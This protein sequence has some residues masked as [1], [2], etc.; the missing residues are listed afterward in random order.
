VASDADDLRE[1]TAEALRRTG[2][3]DVAELGRTP[4]FTRLEAELSMCLRLRLGL[5]CTP[6]RPR[7][8]AEVAR[9]MSIGGRIAE[10]AVAALEDDALLA[11]G[12][13]SAIGRA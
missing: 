4:Q 3:R 5:D 11:L 8:R 2:A 7:T 12:P 9:E 1:L 6:P 10:R 13:P